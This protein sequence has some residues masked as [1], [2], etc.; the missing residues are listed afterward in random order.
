[1]A[2]PAVVGGR[3]V[4][5]ANGMDA[6]F[7]NNAPVAI[8]PIEALEAEKP[9]GHTFDDKI[10]VVAPT[11]AHV[12]LAGLRPHAVGIMQPSLGGEHH[13]HRFE[14]CAHAPVAALHQFGHIAVA[15][16]EMQTGVTQIASQQQGTC[17]LLFAQG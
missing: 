13:V 9:V 3:E 17:E 4:E 11:Y 8:N 2:K 15:E 12:P 6:H 7:G 5:R 14:H 10:V 16:T 1:M